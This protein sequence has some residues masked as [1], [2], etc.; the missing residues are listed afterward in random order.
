MP[1]QKLQFKPGLNRDQTNY[2]NEGGWN[3]CDKI[4]FR[5]GYPQKIGGWLRYGTFVVAG[6]CRQVFNWITTASD[7]YL[8]LGT[9]KKLYIEAGQILNDITPIRATFTTPA[10]DNCFTTVN[11]SKTV[12]VTIVA[13]GATDGDYVTFSGAIAVGGITAPNLNTEFIVDQVTT[14]TFTITVATAATSSTS[15]GGSA[16]TAAFQISVGNAIASIGYGW[17][18][19]TWSRGAWGSGNPT[20]VV[21]VQRDWFL[22]NFDNDLVANIRNGAIYYWQYSGG[23]ATRATLLSTT[24]ISGVAPADVPTEAM[25]ILVSQNDKHLLAFGCTPFGGGA[26]DP[27]LIRFATQDQPNV[28][29]PL[30]TNSAGFL[31]V[32][33][34]SAIVCAVATRQEILVFTEGTLNSLQFLGTT[35][36]FGLQEL[37]DNI[38]ILSPRAVVT[39]NNTAYWMGHDKFYAY[40]GRVETLPCTLR[41]HVFQNLNYEQADQIVSGTNEGWNE[42]WWFYPTA[43]SNINNAYVIYNHLEKIWYYGTIDRTAWS[44]SSLREYPQ[45]ITGTYVTGSISGTTLTITAVTAGSLQVGSVLDGTGVLP[46]TTITALGTGTGGTGTYTVNISQSVVST[47][48]TSDSLIYNHEQGLNDDTVAM[49]SYIASSDFDLVDGDQFILTKRIIP[50]MNFEGSTANTPTVTMLIK[51]RN[52]P[53]NAYT[54]TETGSVIETSVDIYTEQIFMRARARQMAIEVASTEL[55]VQWQL[56]SPRLDGRPDGRR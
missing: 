4:R 28:W 45:A 55:N 25:Q 5:S 1:L 24:T 35:D 46:G 6:I 10:T 18:A 48:L 26:A 33:R 21:N 52:F 40:G 16:I 41:N 36:V 7:N 51:P 9:S 13:H 44:D 22:Q 42:V 34:G 29:T 37:A 31:R 8:A 27:L 17:G 14:N 23:T 38:S 39:V 3:N 30:V 43:N 19:G 53:G 50:D 11:G 2:T 15:G 20:P 49:S 56:G 32:S 54:N 12:T 47:A